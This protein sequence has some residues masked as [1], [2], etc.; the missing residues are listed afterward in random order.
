[1]SEM[2]N[3]EMIGWLIRLKWYCAGLGTALVVWLIGRW[4]KNSSRKQANLRRGEIVKD[5]LEAFRLSDPDQKIA[6]ALDAVI[7]CG[8]GTLPMELSS[9]FRIECVYEDVGATDH[10]YSRKVLVYYRPNHG[11]EKM[12]TIKREYQWAYL[13]SSVRAMFIREKSKRVIE[14]LYEG[15]EKE[16]R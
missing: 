13:P 12:L 8:S 4:A 7:S 11:D 15:K 6:T 14:L 9:V 5:I 16:K 1:M 3:P 10:I 2:S